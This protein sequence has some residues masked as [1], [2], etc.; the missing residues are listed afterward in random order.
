MTQTLLAAM[1]AA[2]PEVK[3]EGDAWGVAEE[4]SAFALLLVGANGP[5][6]LTK[7]RHITLGDAFVTAE[8]AEATWCL[9]YSAILGLR[10]ESSAQAGRP[11]FRR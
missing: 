2:R 4:G 10:V 11:G 3:G 8:S 9:P 1:L 6:P 5:V 7:L